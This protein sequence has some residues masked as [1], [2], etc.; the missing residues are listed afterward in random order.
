MQNASRTY[1]T[2]LSDAQWHLLQPLLPAPN[3]RGRPRAVDLRHLLNGIFYLLQAG[4]AW[5][6]LPKEF[7]PWSTVY[8][9]FRRWSQAGLWEQI[10]LALREQ[11][12]QQAQRDPQPSAAIMDS[13]TIKTS[14]QACRSGID[15]GKKIEGVKRHVLVDPL[16]LLLGV[17]V[18]PAS[19]QDRDGARL[20]LERCLGFFHR[21][22]KVWADS[23]YYAHALLEWV[24]S[25]FP[26]RPLVLEI[27]RRLEGVGGFVVLPKRWIVERTLAW[28]VKRRRLARHYEQRPDHSEGFIYL[29]MIS[30]MLKRLTKTPRRI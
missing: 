7:G 16:G 6:L 19:I 24:A 17:L 13:Q 25:L 14:D 2:D 21:L 23:G 12:R 26:Q 10:N 18:T 22:Q 29:A 8:G 28:L 11:V 30:L 9:Y 4:C 3:R 1:P 20:L 5:R 27:V 15:A